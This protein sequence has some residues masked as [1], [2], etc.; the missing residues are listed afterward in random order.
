[1]QAPILVAAINFNRTQQPFID[2][3][4]NTTFSC[5]AVSSRHDICPEKT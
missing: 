3:L 5:F 4:E 2:F 1:M